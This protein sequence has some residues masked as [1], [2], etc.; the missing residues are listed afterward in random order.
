MNYN[1]LNAHS[2]DALIDFDPQT[3]AYTIGGVEYH[4]VTTVV[5]DCFTPFDAEAMARR[6]ATPERTAQMILDE[7][8]EK[9]RVARELGTLMHDR[10]EHHYLGLTHPDMTTD[11]ATYRLFERFADQRHLNPYRTEWR[12]FSDDYLV[13][14]TLDFLGYDNG[15]FVIYDWKRSSKLLGRD[16]RSTSTHSYGKHAKAPLQHLP[17]ATYYHY[18]LQVSVYRLILSMDYGID[19]DEAYL[20]VFHPDYERPYELEVQYLRREAMTLLEMYRRQD[21]TPNP[22]AYAA[23]TV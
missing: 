2:R 4:S 9:G 13:A 18:A 19:V 21:R 5:D 10:I 17:D 14:G 6:K 12:I 15:R 11:M 8:T 7:W 1:E 3:H 22:H 23:R 20:G 16:C